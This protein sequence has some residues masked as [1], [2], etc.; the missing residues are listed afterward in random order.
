MVQKFSTHAA[1]ETWLNGQPLP[2]GMLIYIK[3]DKNYVFSTNN[4]DGRFMTI[5][6]TYEDLKDGDYPQMILREIERDYNNQHPIPPTPLHEVDPT[7]PQFVK[8]ITEAEIDKWNNSLGFDG[9]YEHLTHKPNIPSK[10]SDLDNDLGYITGYTETEPQWNAAKDNYYT[11]SQIDGSLADKADKSQLNDYT[12]TSGFATIN[13]QS[14][15]NG[16]NIVISGGEGTTDYNALENK[17]TLNGQ[18]LQGNVIL[19]IPSK[20]SQLQNDA[21][22]IS[23]Y[24]ETDPTVPTHVKSITQNDINSWNAKSE[25]LLT[26]YNIGRIA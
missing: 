23:D 24:T 15:T 26:I 11:K 18:T 1:L 13:N 22:Y 25:L 6:G 8:E 21:N 3:E 2:S 17:P 16:G 12:L 5:S 14:I 19:D 10:V 20:V 7:V 9:N 4:I